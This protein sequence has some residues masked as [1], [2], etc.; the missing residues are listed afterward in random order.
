[1]MDALAF[2]DLDSFQGITGFKRA[3]LRIGLGVWRKGKE[4][5]D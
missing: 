4:E 3:F 5:V 1:M 2:Q